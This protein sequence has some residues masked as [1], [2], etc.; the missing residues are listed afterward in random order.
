M[1][2]VDSKILTQH[3][4]EIMKIIWKLEHA[5]VREAYEQLRKRKR[6]AYTTVLTM[7]K[8]LADKGFLRRCGSEGRAHVYEPTRPQG[9]VLSGMVEE[10]VD[11]VFNGSVQP[12]VLSLL[13][14]RRLSEV[15]LTELRAMIDENDRS[16]ENDHAVGDR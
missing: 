4:L 13:R 10:F 3:E 15:E 8:I 16:E 2:A 7:M 1:A 12:L 5:T 11:R 14:D 9:S 6:V